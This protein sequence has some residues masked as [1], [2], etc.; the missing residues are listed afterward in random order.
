MKEETKE[1]TM[2]FLDKAK[3]LFD[4]GFSA[5]KKGL[6]A[7]GIA[8][9]DFSDKSVTQIEI[10]QLESKVKKQYTDLGEYVNST[11]S[12]KVKSISV[13]DEKVSACMKEISRLEKEI[14][15]RKASLD[16]A[17]KTK[18]EKSS[19][20]KSAAVKTSAKKAAPKKAGA[21]KPASSKSETSVKKV[22]SSGKTSTA[23]KTVKK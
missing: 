23:K 7:A 10:K 22:S 8:V 18:S 2:D 19:S 16:D 9:Q 1:K 15:K 5:S 4:R 11:F 20:S 6:K 17:K 21:A 13:T 3:K 12:K 14:S